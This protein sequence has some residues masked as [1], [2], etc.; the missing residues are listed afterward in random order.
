MNFD[1][2]ALEMLTMTQRKFRDHCVSSAQDIVA[3]VRKYRSQYGL[4]YAPIVLIYGLT[5]A[6]RCMSL[7]GTEEEVNYLTKALE[8]CSATWKIGLQLGN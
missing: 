3:L 4:R 1:P 6:S 2:A 7:F 5:Q 8:E